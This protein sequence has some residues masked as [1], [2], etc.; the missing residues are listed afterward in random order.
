MELQNDRDRQVAKFD[1]VL[2]ML[3]DLP[4]VRHTRPATVVSTMPILGDTS[5][6]IVQTFRQGGDYTAA[7]QLVD[8]EGRERIVIPAKVM[9][10]LYRQRETLSDRS[11]PA[12]RARDRKRRELEKR[13][14]ERDERR[15]AWRARQT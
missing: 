11:T 4:D 15:A 5:T 1:R 12:S 10:A 7:L 9:S 13:R 8:A 6:Y 2:G 14:R 3:V